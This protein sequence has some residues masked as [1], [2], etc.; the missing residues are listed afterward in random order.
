MYIKLRDAAAQ[1]TAIEN[2]QTLKSAMV[3]QA[4]ASKAKHLKEKKAIVQE[5]TRM[6]KDSKVVDLSPNVSNLSF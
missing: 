3:G 1:M 6:V 2:A 4:E 5:I